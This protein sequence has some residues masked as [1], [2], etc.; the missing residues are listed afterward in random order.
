M[1]T[2]IKQ[3]T[4]NLFNRFFKRG[5]IDIKPFTELNL[6]GIEVFY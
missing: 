5:F 3:T 1:E 4:R 6:K 2:K